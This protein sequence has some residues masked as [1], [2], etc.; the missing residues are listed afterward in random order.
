[1]NDYTLS[2]AASPVMEKIQPQPEDIKYYLN[3]ELIIDKDT[4]PEV[5]FMQ[6]LEFDKGTFQSARVNTNRW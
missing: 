6:V 4:I 5:L 2:K 1:M 3:L